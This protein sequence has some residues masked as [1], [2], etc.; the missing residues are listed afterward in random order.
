MPSAPSS[1]QRVSPSMSIWRQ[2]VWGFLAALAVI[3]IFPCNVHADS[4]IIET[5]PLPAAPFDIEVEN[6]NRV[7]FTLPAANAIG[8]LEVI[9]M[10][11]AVRYTYTAYLLSSS[12][13]EPYRLAVADGD[14]WFTQRAGNRIG[15]LSI[16]TGTITEYDIPTAVSAPTDIDVAPDGSVWFVQ[17][18]SDRI[19]VLWPAD[20]TIQ[21][22]NV[23][24]TATNLERIDAQSMGI[25]WATAPGINSIFGYRRT[26]G[27]IVE[28]S[29][30]DSS[31][32]PGV[33]RGLA[34]PP[35]GVPWVSTRDVA[36]V[37]SF[38]FGTLAVWLWYPYSPTTADLIDILLIL[39]SGR[40]YLWALDANGQS[41]VQIDLSNRSITQL[42][43]VGGSG[44]NLTALSLDTVSSTVWVADA[45]LSAIYAL[46]PPYARLS[47]LPVV[48]R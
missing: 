40:T 1:E 4:D 5:Y 35:S 13:S 27:D 14:V 41:V 9:S 31:G 15:R 26:A 38:L 3:S 34:V 12:N 43:G 33:V 7:W 30:V 18:N 24:R 6:S 39:E 17:S 44:S 21:E 28:V 11:E 20:G 19:A 46:R 36:K 32:S 48:A 2:I 25:V 42:A 16:A 23:G 45:G 37:G 22:F 47:F 10:T 29:V 8:S